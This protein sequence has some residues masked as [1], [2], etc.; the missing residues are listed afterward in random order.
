MNIRIVTEQDI[1]AILAIYSQYIN[2]PITCEYTLPEKAAFAER[3]K[4][5]AADYP[6]LVCEE[7]GNI[8]GYAYAHRHMERKAYDWNAELSVYLDKNYTS[9]GLGKKLYS[10]LIEILRLQGIKTVI[11]GVVLPNEKSQKLHESLGFDLVGIY[12][13][14]A[15]K[16]D[17]WYDIA[18]YEKPIAAYER[19][20]PIIPFSNIPQ[21]EVYMIIE[22][23]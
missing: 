11:G 5:I 8:I 4:R 2:T 19:P 7:A 6:Y 9:K 22:S 17:Q 21:K 10:Q 16:N 13:H 12:H 14:T 1:D 23:N 3:V 18:W 20:D 15:F